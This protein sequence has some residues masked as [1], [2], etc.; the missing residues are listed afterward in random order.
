[1]SNGA[2]GNGTRTNGIR[3]SVMM[4]GG[5]IASAMSLAT[6]ASRMNNCV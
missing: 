1:M 5:T 6:T 3:R 4:I 2:N